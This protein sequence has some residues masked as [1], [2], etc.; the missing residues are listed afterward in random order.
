MIVKVLAQQIPAF[1]EAI[2]FCTT[3]VDEIDEKELPDYLNNLLRALLNDKAQ[4]FVRLDENRILIGLMITEIVID[5]ITQKV[6]LNIQCLYSY[7]KVSDSDWKIE[8]EFIKNFAEK[9]KCDSVIFRTRNERVMRIGQLVGFEE[10]C[11][12]FEMKLGGL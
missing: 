10:K 12:I 8:Y 2:K 11:R 3:K 5:K 4:C 6:N 1:W 9:T 7:Q